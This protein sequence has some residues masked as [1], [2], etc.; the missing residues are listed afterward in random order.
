M[1]NAVWNLAWNKHLRKECECDWYHVNM[2]DITKPHHD[3]WRHF[4]VTCF[5]IFRLSLARPEKKEYLVKMNQLIKI[6][7][8]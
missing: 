7:A 8:K 2:D 1:Y 4:P 3:T 5:M 6:I